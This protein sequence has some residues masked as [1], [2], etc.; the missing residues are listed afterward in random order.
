[1]W[2]SHE[3]NV[4]SHRIGSYQ[5]ESHTQSIR[6]E[7]FSINSYPYSFEVFAVDVACSKRIENHIL[8][9]EIDNNHKNNN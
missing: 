1:M 2:R 4:L 6:I 9:N 5:L 7:S 3:R 8:I